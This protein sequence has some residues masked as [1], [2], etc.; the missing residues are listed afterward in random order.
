VLF[1]VLGTL[2]VTQPD[3]KVKFYWTYPMG[4]PQTSVME[5]DSGKTWMIRESRGLGQAGGIIDYD[6][7][8]I[9]YWNY[10]DGCKRYGDWK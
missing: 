1:A 8:E 10:A 9:R 3:G 7:R 4:G 2:A 5:F 6:S